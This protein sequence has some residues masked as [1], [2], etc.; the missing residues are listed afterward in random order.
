MVGFLSEK[1]NPA[2]YHG[3]GRKAPFF[4]GWYY[5]LVTADEKHRYAFIPGVFI[6]QDAQKTHS[7]V[8][9]LNGAEATSTY[10][11]FKRFE[12]ADDHYRVEV[13]DGNSFW[14]DGFKV[15][16]ADEQA[17][18]QG[19]IHLKGMKPWPVTPFSLGYMGWLGWIPQQQC[20]HGVLS[21]DHELAGTLT[22]NGE[23][24]D[25]TG[26]RGYMEKD[27]G[28]SFPK[29]Y[30]WMQSN[31][32]DTPGVSLT[33][34]IATVPALGS[35]ATGFGYGLLYDGELYKLATYNRSAVDYLTV[36]DTTVELAVFNSKHELRITASRA[37]GGLLKGPQL[38]DMSQRVVESMSA[39]VEVRLSRL[40]TMRRYPI[41]HGAGRNMALEVVGDLSRI[42]KTKKD[43]EAAPQP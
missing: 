12:A 6:N 8:Q 36:T 10:H 32:F 17:S 30:I 25:F 14:L 28:K 34:S 16:I 42:K 5:K 27:W 35:N 13:G 2:L 3:K 18:I 22:I 1:M 15:N 41:F 23:T 31:H 11:R 38:D 26:G 19:E 29:G 39:T 37:D 21:M 9:V 20:Y 33:G 7:F 43:T 24:I 4:E 40:D